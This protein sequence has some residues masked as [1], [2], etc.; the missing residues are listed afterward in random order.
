MAAATRATQ[1]PLLQRFTRVPAGQTEEDLRRVFRGFEA[2]RKA[3]ETLVL[4]VADART[5]EFLGTISLLRFAWA[6]C[7]ADVGYWLAPEAQG[8]GVVTRALALLSRWALT[9]SGPG[10]GLGLKTLGLYTDVDNFASQRVAERRGFTREEVLAANETCDWRG[11]E[12]V[13]FSRSGP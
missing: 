13:R 3:G 2:E 6:E 7:T 10:L 11:V 12:L 8:R 9:D 5:D 4:A 1:D